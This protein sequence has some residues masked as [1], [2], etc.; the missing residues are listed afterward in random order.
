MG[1]NSKEDI[2]ELPIAELLHEMSCRFC[3][4]PAFFTVRKRKVK[5]HGTARST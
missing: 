2:I 3:N 1:A 5:R 4:E